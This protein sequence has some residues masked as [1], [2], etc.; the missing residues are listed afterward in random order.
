VTAD[1][2]RLVQ[3]ARDEFEAERARFRDDLTRLERR[4]AALERRSGR[5]RSAPTR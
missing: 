2:E 1:R 4:G 3:T 5:S